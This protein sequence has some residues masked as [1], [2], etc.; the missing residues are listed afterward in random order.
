M[1]LQLGAAPARDL[2]GSA[3]PL[4]RPGP[5]HHR[6]E[7]RRSGHAA[8]QHGQ[9]VPHTLCFVAEP[10]FLFSCSKQLSIT[11]CPSVTKEF[12]KEIQ[13]ETNQPTSHSLSLER[14]QLL[15]R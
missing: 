4:L 10:V 2:V 11:R 8:V 5:P 3:C 7:L 6:L 15:P 13:S 14:P 12:L 9:P 1:C